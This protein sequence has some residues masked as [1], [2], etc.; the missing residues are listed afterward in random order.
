MPSQSK[1]HPAWS[2][3]CGHLLY[4]C[5]S[6]RNRSVPACMA[7]AMCGRNRTRRS[8]GQS[9][10]RVP[11]CCACRSDFIRCAG[12]RGFPGRRTNQSAGRVVVRMRD[13][14]EIVA[15]FARFARELM[16]VS[17]V[18]ALPGVDDRGF[19]QRDDPAV[20]RR[21]VDTGIAIGPARN[22]CK[23]R[24]C[25]RKSECVHRACRRPRSP[26]RGFVPQLQPVCR[27]DVT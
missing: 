19:V 27:D 14:G 25:N 11:N 7:R 20:C 4:E 23:H 17:P 21:A 3:R 16:E 26:G 10:R 9:D 24:N 8:T 13:G 22:R 5:V 1:R 6:A 15:E 2:L 12:E 18:I